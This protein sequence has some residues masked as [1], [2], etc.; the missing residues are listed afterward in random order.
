[1]RRIVVLMLPVLMAA[2]VVA[3]SCTREPK[4]AAPSAAGGSETSQPAAT[5]AAEPTEAA[6]APASAADPEHVAPGTQAAMDKAIAYLR[7]T[8]QADGGW[9]PMEKAEAT[10]MG[11]SSVA[12]L[13]LLRAGVPADDPMMVKAVNYLV[14]FQKDD[15]GIYDK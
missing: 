8:Q 5:P 9:L 11:I 6:P 7:Q 12:T 2:G 4:P 1:M 10:E 13:G 14:G 3:A 15:G